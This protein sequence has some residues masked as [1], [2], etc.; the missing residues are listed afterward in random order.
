MDKQPED[1][2]KKTVMT[3][4]KSPKGKYVIHRGLIDEC[5]YT[6]TFKYGGAVYFI[7]NG[8]KCVFYNTYMHSQG[9]VRFE[10][11]AFLYNSRMDNH[12]PDIK[13][14]IM[15][16]GNSIFTTPETHKPEI[17][18]KALNKKL[19]ITRD[20]LNKRTIYKLD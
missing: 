19:I 9:F 2:V 4:Y 18:V 1:L 10:E 8:T 12:S 5:K 3:I 15:F 13:K 16:D 17:I 14:V 20:T 6:V 11:V 7:F